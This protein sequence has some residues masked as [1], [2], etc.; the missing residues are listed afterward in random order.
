MATDGVKIIDGDAA[1]DTYSGI[2]D[3]YDSDVDIELIEKE[4]PLIQEDSLDFD[5]EIY[6]TACALAYW[7]IG[8]LKEEYL[9]YIRSVID[10][11][12]CVEEWASY[13][14]KLGKDRQKELDKFWKKISQPNR[15]PRAKKKFR[16]ITSFIFRENDVL[17]FQ[18][19]NGSYRAAVCIEVRQHRGHCDYIL[20]PTTY[21]SSRKPT[22]ADL[23]SEA[24]LGHE[25]GSGFSKEDIKIKQPGIEELWDYSGFDNFVF[26]IVKIGIDHKNLISFKDR[27][28]KIG[29]LIVK[30]PFR[31]TGSLHYENSFEGFEHYFGDLKETIRAFQ[32]KRYPITLL[33]EVQEDC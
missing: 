12:A 14:E 21:Q 11:N 33:C 23:N 30:A 18:V 1:H 8:L 4:F 15:K 2:M 28:E 27:F 32:E 24:M 29:Q 19:S 26:G 7:E 9:A 17:A 31:E 6:V 5:K 3:L 20:T 13:G 10:K 22:V 16:K 25:I